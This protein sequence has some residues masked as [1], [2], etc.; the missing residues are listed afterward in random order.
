MELRD[1]QAISNISQTT[2]KELYQLKMKINPTAMTSNTHSNSAA[3]I[4][5]RTCLDIH[6][7]ACH[8][9]RQNEKVK[10]SEGKVVN[11]KLGTKLDILV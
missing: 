1:L 10:N 6:H 8:R 4:P 9:M 2:L 3:R 11:R 5:T 7:Y